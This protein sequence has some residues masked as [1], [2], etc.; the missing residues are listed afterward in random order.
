MPAYD[1]VV[2]GAGPVGA[3][4]AL[5]LARAGLKVLLVEAGGDCA[6]DLRASTLH[7]PTLDM[8]HDLGLAE[9]HAQGLRAPVYR[10]FNRQSG[11]SI[12]FDLSELHDVSEHPYR[13]QCEQWK[14]AR[15]ASA[16]VAAAAAGEVRFNRRVV[17]FS[18]DSTGVDLHLEA[19]TEIETVRAS[20]LVACDGANSLI[21]KWLG[22]GFE[23]FTYPEKFLCL[24]TTLPMDELIPGICRVNYMADPNEW[25]VLLQAP[26]AWR[27]LVPARETDA[28]SALLSDAKKDAVFS[29]L[30]GGGAAVV[31]AHRT[32][33][34]VHQRVATNYRVGRVL[35]AGDAAHVNN[36]LGGLG[37]NSGIHD[38]WN[39][40][41]KLIRILGGEGGDD[42]LDHYVRQR[43]TIMQEFVQAQTMRNK[44]DIEMT[45]EAAVREREAELR[46]IAADPARRRAYL[47][48]QSLY[49]SLRREADI[50]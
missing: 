30:I 47:M 43:R 1:V 16:R 23:G 45:G 37:M 20:Y 2:A 11:Q 13:L 36:P 28:D 29:S 35:L 15:L 38:V 25:M 21:R 49:T 44:L 41:H 50:A 33:Y 19:P 17:A 32:I 22:V 27:V 46:A 24:S 10:F 7:P 5:I 3:T 12:G 42:L 39:L 48:Q 9:L 31:T 6:G 34:R 14:L 26:T 18:Q 40:C 8:L 4:A